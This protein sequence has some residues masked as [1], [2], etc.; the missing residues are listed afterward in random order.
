MYLLWA[1]Y[2]FSSSFYHSLFSGISLFPCRYFV[3]PST[4]A[5][6]FQ[7]WSLN[8]KLLRKSVDHGTKMPKWMELS[9][10]RNFIEKVIICPLWYYIIVY[11][12]TFRCMLTSYLDIKKRSLI[13]LRPLRWNQK[14]QYHWWVDDDIIHKIKKCFWYS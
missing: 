4:K 1:L 9:P 11:N 2:W 5:H 3:R 10:K 6:I 8:K 12:I 13:F 14:L 7:F